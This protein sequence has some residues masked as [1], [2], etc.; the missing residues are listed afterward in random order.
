[1]PSLIN[2][3]IPD[4]DKMPAWI[5]QNCLSKYQRNTNPSLFE[6]DPQMVCNNFNH[7]ILQSLNPWNLELLLYSKIPVQIGC[8]AQRLQFYPGKANVMH[9]YFHVGL[10]ANTYSFT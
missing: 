6:L 9:W 7:S 4:K 1:M 3:A 8:H 10:Q 5:Y 2:Q